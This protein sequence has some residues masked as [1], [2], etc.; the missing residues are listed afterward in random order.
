MTA[1]P[2]YIAAAGIVSPLGWGLDATEA[3]LRAD[4][5]AIAP[6]R[7][8]PPLSGAPLPVGQ[9]DDLDNSF[10]PPRT[11]RLAR[12]AARLAM[13]GQHSP[14]E[15]VVLGCTTGGILTT[16]QLLRERV[17]DKKAFQYHGLF[18]LA[19]DI[20]DCCGCTGP[21]L[22]VSTACSS[23][24]LALAL[25][26]RLLRSGRVGSVLAGGVDSLSR[27]T[28]FGFHS[29]QLVDVHGCRPL[30]ASRQGLAVAEGAA[31]L[32]LTTE[33]PE[34]SLGLLLGA[35]LSCDAHH[36]TAPHPEG[37]GARTAMAAALADAGLG[38]NDIDHIS[39][40][41][42]GTPDNDLA[43][44]RAIRDLFP[45]PPPLASIK[46]ATGHSLAAAGAIEAVVA[47]LSVDRS[48]IPGTTGCR[49]PDPALGLSPQLTC[50]SQPVRTVLSNSF[51]FGGN[52]GSLVIG[53]ADT[54]SA[55]LPVAQ[56]DTGE[57]L[58][59]HGSACLTGT[60]LGQAT[61]DRLLA[62]K[63]AAGRFAAEQIEALL[64]ARLIR[65]LKRL[66]RL[67]LLLAIAARDEA[68]E[69][70][71]PAAV[72]LGTGW[73]ALSETWD[74]LDRLTET[75]EQFPSP[76]DFVGSVH[77]GAAG[78][79]A[80]QFQATSANCTASGGDYSFEQALLAAQALL[81]PTESAV[82]LG[83]DEGHDR[84]SPLLD[85]SITP[86]DSL[87][88]GGGALYVNR[89]PQC[90]RCLV[91]LALYGRGGGEHLTTR[92][93]ESLGGAVRLRE[94][95]VAVFAGTPAGAIDQG[96]RQLAELFE[97]IGGPL[98]LWRYRDGIG[99]FASASAAASGLAAALVAAG[100]VPSRLAGIGRDIAIKPGQSI[101]VLGTGPCLTAMEFR[102][103]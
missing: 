61:L 74:F 99:Q 97:Q 86:G 102:R 56:N 53:R 49:Q 73:G 46:G 78:Q 51:G 17:D 81:G 88:D 27:L 14:P 38:P 30:D 12:E 58:A 65:R 33:R 89:D 6:L 84:L 24:A 101:L 2:V 21:A 93:V 41:G 71:K 26:L 19:E 37:R 80:M 79:I 76:I 31:L 85:G 23:G 64:P 13:A 67:A 63:S 50:T 18:S 11:H 1:R 75:R 34:Q 96:E 69:R 94:R 9:V 28:Y 32:L 87:A 43:E 44:A 40:H 82:L 59:V 52:N 55:K 25:A 42:T 91:R 5:S 90:A 60:G 22:A 98:P 15:A 57:F 10:W 103:P 48:F 95:C 92:L 20:A 62:G 8:F 100:A 47:A 39:L 3:A 72:F 4:R 68:A 16:E 7:V 35:G 66:P 77:N 54:D 83:A 29:L 70:E 36:P 45:H